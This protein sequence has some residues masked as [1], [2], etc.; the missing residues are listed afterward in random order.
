M[1]DYYIEEILL[2]AYAVVAFPM[3]SGTKPTTLPENLF[4]VDK[5]REKLSPR[6]A[7]M[8]H[9]LVT[10]RT[11]YASTKRARPADTCTTMIAFLAHHYKSEG[12]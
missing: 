7:K 12:T 4:E 6:M 1:L 3:V 8:F 5:D 10:K 11:L 2:A 9:N